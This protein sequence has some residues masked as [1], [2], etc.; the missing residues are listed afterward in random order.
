MSDERPVEIVGPEMMVWLPRTIAASS[1]TISLLEALVIAFLS[2]RMRL[3]AEEGDGGRAEVDP[4]TTT[5]PKPIETM[6]SD[7]VD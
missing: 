1:T 2:M 4:L 3:T 5:L 6:V 7:M